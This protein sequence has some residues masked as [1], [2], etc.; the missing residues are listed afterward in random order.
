MH[1]AS[2]QEPQRPQGETI[3]QVHLPQ[4]IEACRARGEIGQLSAAVT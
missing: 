4:E 2:D 1:R 3:W